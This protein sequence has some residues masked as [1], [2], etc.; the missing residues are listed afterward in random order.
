MSFIDGSI[1]VMKG[2]GSLM[3]ST[4]VGTAG[5][6]GKISN[7]LGSAMLYLTGDDEFIQER[8]RQ[9]IKD[10]PTGMMSGI[11]KGIASGVSSSVSGVKGVFTKPIEGARR[12]GISGFFKGTLNGIAGLI[13]KPVA[14]AMDMISKT[15]Q[16]IENASLTQA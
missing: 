9:G 12:D 13:V 6:L 11:E 7:S 15:T 8:T 16:G 10:K 2:T 1:G 4:L 5:S 3:K 14:G